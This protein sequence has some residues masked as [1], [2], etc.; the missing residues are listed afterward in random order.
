MEIQVPE[1]KDSWSSASCPLLWFC[2]STC[3]QTKYCGEAYTDPREP[4]EHRPM[5]IHVKCIDFYIYGL[6]L[7]TWP[8]HILTCICGLAYWQSSYGLH[9][10][11]CHCGPHILTCSY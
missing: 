4:I 2:S 3:S 10:L 9:I 7:L 5:S 6:H 11:T 1:W 8:L